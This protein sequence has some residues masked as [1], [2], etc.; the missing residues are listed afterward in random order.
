MSRLIAA[1]IRGGVAVGDDLAGLPDGTTVSVLAPAGDE[2][3]L[4]A[5]QLDDLDIA[6]DEADREELAPAED[7]MRRLDSRR[8]T[9]GLPATR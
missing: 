9:A 2:A 6:H 5:E 4:T 1:T 8:A 3:A 7:V